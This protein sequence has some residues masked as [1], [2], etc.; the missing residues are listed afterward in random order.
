MGKEE[1]S[2]ILLD[3]NQA[4]MDRTLKYYLE[5]QTDVVVT[6][7]DT[8][9]LM[10]MAK[11]K[12]EKVSVGFEL[13]KAPSDLMASLRDGRLITQLPRMTE[14]FDMAY[15]V[16]VGDSERIDLSSGKIEEK[17]KGG[18]WGASSFSYHYLNSIM[19]RFEASG[20]RVRH[21]RDTEHLVALIMSIMR[22]WKKENHTE[23][24]FYRKRH[25]FIDW[26]LLDNPLME[27][28]ERMG[29][30]I[31]RAGLLANKYPTLELLVIADTKELMALEGFGKRTVDK[32]MDFIR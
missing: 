2:M 12:D 32:V 1:N 3:S 10:F 5:E 19:T 30:G 27:M 25:K 6:P 13:K 22:F 20:G 14:E 7:L 31:K 21:V 9:D 23:E 11:M 29:I 15:L 28:Y 18:K 17:V 4:T 24:V 26:K 8:A 16:T